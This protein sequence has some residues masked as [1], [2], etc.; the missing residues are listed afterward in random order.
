MSTCRWCC[1]AGLTGLAACLFLVSDARAQYTNHLYTTAYSYQ[2]LAETTD[3]PAKPADE[4]SPAV[5]EEEAGDSECQA[6]TLF[7][8]E[9][10]FRIGG[11]MQGGYHDGSTGLFNDRPGKFNLHQTWLWIENKADGDKGFDIGYRADFVYGID[12]SDTQAFGNPPGTWDFQNGFDHGDYAWA[13]PQLYGEVAIN[14]LSVKFG[15]FYTLVGYEVVGAPGNFFYSHALTMY[16]SEPFTH[17]GMVASYSAS[18]RLTLHGG[19]TAGWDTGFER[20]DNGSS[21]L[22]GFSYQL[23]DPLKMTYISTA[24]DLGWRGEGYSHSLVFD[25]TI[26]E[27]WH[28]VLQSD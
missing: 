12:G 22:G 24:G 14:D 6:W 7:P 21:W 27:K 9:C 10:E 23:S 25:W 8:E 5:A 11:W 28:Y 19:W 2:A 4:Y 18:D 3:V 17:T 1:F 16:N 20:F 15:H 13:L 26:N